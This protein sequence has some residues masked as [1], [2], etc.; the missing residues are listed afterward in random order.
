MVEI[1]EKI[2]LKIVETRTYKNYIIDYFN[3]DLNYVLE[4]CNLESEDPNM[5]YCDFK[6]TFNKVAI[7]HVPIR[8]RKV[9]SEY[10]PRLDES[11][12]KMNYRDYI[13]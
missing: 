12:T 6:N 10:S 4:E 11:I 1:F 2:Q 7:I 8:T 3:S 9:R 13:K 5:L